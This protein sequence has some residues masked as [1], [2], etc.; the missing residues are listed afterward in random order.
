MSSDYELHKQKKLEE[1]RLTKKKRVAR[2]T[3]F[4][5]PIFLGIA[6]TVGGMVYFVSREK[7]IA[8][9]NLTATAIE[10][11]IAPDDQ[12]KGG[13]DAKAVL[14]EYSDFQCPA[15]GFYYPV[16][17]SLS[18]EF[19]NNLAIVYRHF[20]L[21][22]HQ[23]AKLMA[24]AA[25]AAGKQGK[26]W[27]MHDMIF[28]NQKN[29]VNLRN[30]KDIILGYAES[31]ELNIGQFKEAL[32]SKEIQQKVEKHYRDGVRASINSTPTFFLNGK[33]ISNP[34]NYDEFRNIIF[35]AIDENS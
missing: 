2:Q 26:F 7:P 23:H 31:L 28:D 17:K 14:V 6:A 13:Q 30:V 11:I 29:W 22:Q 20:P 9:N 25:E 24:S 34:R 3:L 8:T 19:G 33:K 12:I 35:Q 10:N 5:L 27:E 1:K 18:E 32:E 4:W 15:C 21:P 16:V